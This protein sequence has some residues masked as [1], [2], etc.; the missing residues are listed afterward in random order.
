MAQEIVDIVLDSLDK[1]KKFSNRELIDN[2][3]WS[4]QLQPYS[5]IP[6]LTSKSGGGQVQIQNLYNT[7]IEKNLDLEDDTFSRVP[8]P[9]NYD[10]S[11]LPEELIKTDFDI[12]LTEFGRNCERGDVETYGRPILVTYPIIKMKVVVSSGRIESFRTV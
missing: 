8:V 11:L 2:Y 9:F 4:I 3:S 12:N 1:V 6:N 5:V 10:E 7:L